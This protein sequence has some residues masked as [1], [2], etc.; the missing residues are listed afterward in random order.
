[1]KS[2]SYRS[3]LVRLALFLS[4]VLCL[5]TFASPAYTAT[6]HAAIHT[7]T[8]ALTAINDTLIWAN[9]AVASVGGCGFFGPSLAL[10]VT[11]N[12]HLSYFD[13]ALH[14]LVY[15]KLT[16]SGWQTE[17]VDAS[18]TV[19]LYSSLA[20]D[21]HGYPHIS[22][23]DG[24]DDALKYAA[25]DGTNW[26][27]EFIGNNG[28][29]G[30]YSS[31]VLDA[32]D[33]PHIA[34]LGSGQKVKYA[35]W[36]G[37]NWDIAVVDPIFA[38]RGTSLALDSSGHPHISYLNDEIDELRYASLTGSSWVTETVEIG[39]PQGANL[40]GAYSSLALDQMDT[41]HISYAR[42]GEDIGDFPNDLRYAV[43]QGGVWQTSA[44]TTQ[45]A[46]GYYSSIALDTHNNPHISYADQ[47]QTAVRYIWWD[48]TTWR[49]SFVA[50]S[51][52]VSGSTSLKLDKH[53]QPH[54]AYCDDTAS[55]INYAVTV[56]PR[57]FLP[58]IRK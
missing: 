53:D 52:P 31:L 37:T 55:T 26:K 6:Y 40:S 50:H 3:L 48:G 44:L 13:A 1:M 24:T 34:Y 35:Y 28:E 12:P 29:S 20:L 33:Q 19:G 22:Y 16:S 18:E 47:S 7:D 15:A 27:V 45:G 39:S 25:W 41:P 17:T 58:V 46:V 51:V 30:W 2:S 54:V 56:T 21:Q 49:D 8:L 57:S 4:I 5:G 14:G 36:T 10:D 38:S 11:G 23:R 43:K 9:T 42:Y 32:N